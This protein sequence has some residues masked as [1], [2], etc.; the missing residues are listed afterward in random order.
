MGLVMGALIDMPGRSVAQRSAKKDSGLALINETLT[1]IAEPL[2]VAEQSRV[3]VQR[4]GL[5]FLG[6]PTAFLDAA[7]VVR[8]KMLRDVA[9]VEEARSALMDIVL[10]PW[11]NPL[12]P[13]NAIRMLGVLFGTLTKKKAGDE[14]SAMLLA[15]CADIFNPINETIAASTRLWKPVSRHPVVLALAIKKL[16]ATSVFTPPPS[17]LRDAM[18]EANRRIS[19]LEF[20]AGEWLDL[21]DRAD[22]VVW[23]FDREAWHAAFVNL[24]ISIPL[25]IQDR[26]QH[27]EGAGE[28]DEPPSPRFAA[29]E[30]LCNEKHSADEA[31]VE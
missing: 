14:N 29:L 21:F 30:K 23:E 26:I 5:P 20:W 27:D 19:R 3:M 15:C 4:G 16:I 31:A 24:D 6:E 11:R 1:E 9:K 2:A 12:T 25:A 28:D 22:L 7:K 18:I 10:P 8:A 17:E 13:A